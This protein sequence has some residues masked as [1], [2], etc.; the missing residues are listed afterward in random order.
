MVIRIIEP[1]DTISV[2][3]S[4]NAGETKHENY[5]FAKFI[6]AILNQ[7]EWGKNWRSIQN[8]MEVDQACRNADGKAFE[9]SDSPYNMLKQAV[10]NPSQGYLIHPLILRQISPYFEAVLDAK[11]KGAKSEDN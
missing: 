1:P 3:L 2:E 7:T 6:E 5:T 10:E 9:L 4:N 11:K 8:A